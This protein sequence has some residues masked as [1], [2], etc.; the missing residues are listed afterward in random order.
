MT[1]AIGGVGGGSWAM[2]RPDPSNMVKNL[3]AKVDTKNQGYIDKAEL[4]S[5]FDQISTNAA[6]GSSD[7]SSSVDAIFKKLDGD[8]DGK[9]TKQ[10]MTD[11]MQKL[12]AQFD[13]QFNQSR[14]S[15][16]G[17]ARHSDDGGDDA[18]FSKDQ[19]SS[20]AK[21]IGASDSKR[22]ELMSKI[23]DNFDKADTNGDGKVNGSEAMAFDKASQTASTGS[24]SSTAAVEGSAGVRHAHGAPPPPPPSAASDSASD[25]SSSSASKVFAAADTN[26]DGKVSIQELLASLQTDSSSDSSSATSS[27]KTEDSSAAVMKMVMQLM[28]AYGGFGQDSAQS[29]SSGISV[30]A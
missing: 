2:Q 1:S 13:S 15:G 29:S 16:M 5:A 3:F 4:Q 22:S 30:A 17:G 12:A 20:M 9:I 23:A 18:G 25:D 14:T 28:Q 19:L 21:D 8:S 27:N 26:Q 6:S 10:E 24:D 7:T 11:G